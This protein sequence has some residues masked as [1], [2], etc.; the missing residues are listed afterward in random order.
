MKPNENINPGNKEEKGFLPFMPGKN[1]FSTPANYFDDLPVNIMDRVQAGSK[2]RKAF[3][4]IKPALAIPSLAILAGAVVF[5]VFLF[6]KNNVSANEILLSENE[7]QHIVSDP[8]S[9]YIDD[10]S[11]TE[12]YINDDSSDELLNEESALPEDQVKNY[13]EEN[14]T[15]QTIINEY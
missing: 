5:L 4:S 10:A 1:P 8:E 2:E 7:V 12:E 13:L 14:T 11:I 3:F 6:N 15:T 9:Y